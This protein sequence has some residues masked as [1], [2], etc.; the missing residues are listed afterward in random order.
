MGGECEGLTALSGH[1]HDT[2][3]GC[4]TG[5]HSPRNLVRADDGII[6]SPCLGKCMHSDSILLQ[7]VHHA[8][9]HGTSCAQIMWEVDHIKQH[10]GRV[11]F[12]FTK[13]GTYAVAPPE[14]I[15]ILVRAQSSAPASRQAAP[16]GIP[17]PP[18]W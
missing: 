2:I 18:V 14:E 9:A 11:M 5:C 4:T 3:G 6:E 15:Y 12:G 10:K 13:I 8:T 1:S 16:G 7:R 17:P